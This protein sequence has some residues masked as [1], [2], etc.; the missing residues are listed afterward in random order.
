MKHLGA[1]PVRNQHHGMQTRWWGKDSRQYM[2]E[3]L[4][5]ALKK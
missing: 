5:W 4:Q 1:S 3:L 2:S